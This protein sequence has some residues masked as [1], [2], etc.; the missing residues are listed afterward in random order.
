MSDLYTNQTLRGTPPIENRHVQDTIGSLIRRSARRHPEKEAFK[1]RGKSYTFSEVNDLANRFAN[2]VREY[3]VEGGDRLAVMAKNSFKY[4]LTWLGTAKSSAV[5]VPLHG[6]LKPH[7]YDFFIEKAAPSML[8]IDQDLLEG[9]GDR[10]DDWDVSYISFNPDPDEDTDPSAIPKTDPIVRFSDLLQEADETEPEVAIDANDV[11]QMMFTSGTTSR[12]KG[13]MHSHSNF[14]SQYFTCITE[15]PIRREDRTLA[16]MPMYHVAQLHN[17]TMPGLYMGASE[18]IL[19]DFDPKTIL[20]TMEAEGITLMILF[21]TLYRQMTERDDFEEY[22][23]GSFR[24]GIYALQM[25]AQEMEASYGVPFV[26]LF[27]QTEMASVTT[28][29][30]PDDQPEKAGAVGRPAGNT[31]VAIMDEMGNLLNAGEVGEIVYRG[32]QVMDGYFREDEKT[33]EAFAHGWFHSGDL[34]RFDEDG[35][36][37]FVDRKKDIIKTGGENVSTIEVEDAIREV[38]DVSEAVVVG[39]PHERWDEAVTAFVTRRSDDVTEEDVI[40]HCKRQL[41]SYKVPKSVVFVESYP[42]SASGKIQKHQL[43]EEYETFYE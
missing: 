39:L 25:D 43:Q 7:E 12:P 33:E 38:S 13:V 42:E 3:G 22:D 29:L 19:R 6:E 36:L 11:V 24:R 23:L 35:V 37:W 41:A 20:Q 28:V 14:I 32:G 1:F 40:E 30:H 5:H 15:I 34:G 10:V 21:A 26:K 18:V 16:V 8:V 2:G 31:E 17:V 4:L 27:G 9:V